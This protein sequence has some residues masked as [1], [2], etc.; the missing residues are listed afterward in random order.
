VPDRHTADTITDDALDALYEQLAA[1]ERRIGNMQSSYATLTEMCRSYSERAIENGQ[2]ADQ[3]EMYARRF[4]LAWKSARKGRHTLSDE[5]TRRA[6][7]LGQ[8]QAALARVWALAEQWENALAPDRR[9]A[10]ALRAALKE[11]PQQRETPPRHLWQ[12]A[13]AEGCPACSGTNPP[14]PF[15]CP[16]PDTTL[17]TRR[18]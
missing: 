4:Y 8:S 15:L 6:P 13:N 12:G 14:Y 11:Q 17:E 2:C 7:L 18:A 9:Y 10:E 1:A 3:W 16:G 5:V